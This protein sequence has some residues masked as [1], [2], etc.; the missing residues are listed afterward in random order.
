MKKIRVASV[1]KKLQ[2]M[3]GLRALS[4]GLKRKDYTYPGVPPIRE[5]LVACEAGKLKDELLKLIDAGGLSWNQM[6]LIGGAV[7]RV[8]GFELTIIK[9]GRPATLDGNA[10]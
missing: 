5:M 1:S 8:N 9:Q 10:I 4:E 3:A 6:I 7:A 2:N